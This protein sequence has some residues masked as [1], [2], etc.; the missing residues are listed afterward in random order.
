MNIENCKTMVSNDRGED[1]EIK[2]GGSA[3]EMVENVCLAAL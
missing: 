3:M 2:I 1:T